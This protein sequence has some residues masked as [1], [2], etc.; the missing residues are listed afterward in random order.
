MSEPLLF[1]QTSQE[2]RTYEMFSTMLNN[3]F[4]NSLHNLLQDEVS[5]Q[6]RRAGQCCPQ[7]EAVINTNGNNNQKNHETGVI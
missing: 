3:H 7:T 1:Q 4:Q 2:Q 6:L 5:S